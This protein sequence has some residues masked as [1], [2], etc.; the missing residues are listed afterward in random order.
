ML[1][2]H[3]IHQNSFLK[4]LESQMKPCVYG[5]TK[6]SSRQLPPREGIGDTSIKTVKKKVIHKHL[7]NPINQIPKNNTYMLECPL[8]SNEMTLKDK[9]QCLKKPSQTMKLS[10]ILLQE[11]ISKDLVCSKFWR[12]SLEEMYQ[13]LWLPIETDFVDLDTTSLSTSSKNTK[14]TLEYSKIQV[15]KSLQEN[16]QKTSWQSLQFLQPDIMDP[17]NIRYCRKIRIYPNVQQVSLFNRSIGASRYFYNQTI[18]HIKTLQANNEKISLTLAS[19][20]RHVMRKDSEIANDDKMSWQKDIPYDTRD[21]AI[22]DA[23][24]AFKATFTNLKRKNITHFDIKFRTKKH[25]CQSFKVNPNALNKDARIFVTRLKKKSKL[26]VRKRDISTILNNGKITDGFFTILKTKSHKWYICLPRTKEKPIYEESAYKSVFLDPGV[27]TFQTFYSPE[28]ISGKIGEGFSTSL[29]SLAQRHDLLLHTKD[30]LLKN[31]SSKT[32]RHIMK[33]CAIL[34]EKIQNKT[35]D[36]HNKTMKFLCDHFE[37]IFIPSFEVSSMTYGSPLGSKVTRKLLVLS[38][39]RFKDKLLA[40][41]KAKKRNVYIVSESY[42]SKTCGG[43]GNLENIGRE[44]VLRCSKCT[45]E[46]DRDY[47]GSRNICLLMTSYLA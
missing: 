42:T 34:R 18:K 3:S 44:S 46:I 4:S 25:G 9:L 36:L 13:R 29:G 35:D 22:Q 8:T 14:C 33:R 11:S 24:I 31:A 15:S 37:N 43:C 21:Q 27:R 10:K 30:T 1:I 16:S 26:R 39:G 2:Q 7:M 41:S 20:R 32:K 19:V 40:Y 12:P 6:D 38:H 45:L 5:V 17:E 28:G 47:N 23:L